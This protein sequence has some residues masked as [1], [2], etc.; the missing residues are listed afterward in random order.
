MGSNWLIL[1]LCTLAFHEPKKK[2][3]CFCFP[4][5]LHR[6][7]SPIAPRGAIMASPAPE[8]PSFLPMSILSTNKGV[9]SFCAKILLH[10]NPTRN[11][12]PCIPFLHLLLR[13]VPFTFSFSPPHLCHLCMPFTFTSLVQRITFACPSL[14][15]ASLPPWQ[16]ALLP[17][18]WVLPARAVVEAVQFSGVAPA[19]RDFAVVEAV[20]EDLRL[21]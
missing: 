8:R 20:A 19:C 21:A 10:G 2:V 1:H 3:L 14:L 15:L 17:S 18:I 13:Q 4:E 16:P 6:R 9:W 7:V 5:F 11:Y 12:P